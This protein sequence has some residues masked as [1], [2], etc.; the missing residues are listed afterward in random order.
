MKNSTFSKTDKRNLFNMLTSAEF[1][2]CVINYY[3]HSVLC[4]FCLLLINSAL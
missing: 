4:T 1:D 3:N 2:S